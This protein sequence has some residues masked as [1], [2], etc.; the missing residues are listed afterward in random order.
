M[1]LNKIWSLLKQRRQVIIMQG[2]DSQWIGDGVAAYS[3]TN[4]LD[5]TE[6][7]IQTLLDVSDKA[8]DNFNYEVKEPAFNTADIVGNEIELKEMPIRVWFKE[9]E[10]TVL[11]GNGK[12]YFIQ[13]KY[14][15]PLRN[16]EYLSFTYR[17]DDKIVV[18]RDGMF[19]AGVICPV[20]LED[21]DFANTI[22]E[23]LR[24]VRSR[25]KEKHDD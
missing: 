18:A 25:P 12:A 22:E 17:P 6:G 15:V 16:T 10:L 8:W 9:A 11:K 21:T 4:S 24:L 5:L 13:S 23:L 20:V 14:T 2:D 19:I 1:K 3:I 7:I